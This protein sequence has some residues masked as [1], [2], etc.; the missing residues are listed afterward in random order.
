MGSDGPFLLASRSAGKIRELNGILA[1]AGLRAVN[2]SKAGIP[3]AAEEDAIECHE[4]FEANALAKARYFNALSGMP[5][6]ADDSGLCVDALGGAPGVWSKRYSGRS[7]LVGQDLDEA[8]NAKLV[9]ALSEV[10]DIRAGYKCAAA[11]VGNGVE[12]VEMGEVRG[13]IVLTPRGDGG[14]GYD[15]YFLS[16]ELGLTF[17]ESSVEAKEQISHR[18]RAFRALLQKLSAATRAEG[19]SNA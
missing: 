17:G 7:D 18:G 10:T 3:P 5:T 19:E 2:L 1:S 11:F 13:Q 15:P 8:N 6:L 9:Q 12:V 14:F 16:T 4:T